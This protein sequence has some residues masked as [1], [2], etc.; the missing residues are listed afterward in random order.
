MTSQPQELLETSP[1]PSPS[2]T[3]Q[4]ALP[5]PSASPFF[6][7]SSRPTPTTS[8]D[9]SSPAPG[10]FP[11][12]VETSDRLDDGSGSEPPTDPSKPRTTGRASI[13]EIAKITRTAVATVTAIAH[14]ALTSE[15]TLERESGLWLADQDDINGIG[16]PLAAI[17]ARRLPEGAADAET[18]D[19]VRLAI[20]V[21]GYVAKNVMQRR[22]IRAVY[23][24]GVTPP[25]ATDQPSEAPAGAVL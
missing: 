2:T 16:D 18:G 6:Q 15:G 5:K 11:T 4:P 22:N 14:E 20:A 17:A 21:F 9:P 12:P 7:P 23:A 24:A 8:E 25:D 1:Q 19:F 3:D 13:R 10:S